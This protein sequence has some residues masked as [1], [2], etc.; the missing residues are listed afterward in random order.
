VAVVTIEGAV[1][2]ALPPLDPV[3]GFRQNSDLSHESK[4]V[5]DIVQLPEARQ[6][7]PGD[8]GV[9]LSGRWLLIKSA[10]QFPTDVLQPGLRLRT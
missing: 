3:T 2:G 5:H 1:A 8:V 4:P 10:R 9:E 7:L 6:N